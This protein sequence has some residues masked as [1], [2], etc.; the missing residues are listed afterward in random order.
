MFEILFRNFWLI[1]IGVSVL[2]YFLIRKKIKPFIEEDPSREPGY[3]QY[4]N[5]FLLL[6]ILPWLIV[7][8]ASLSGKV[9]TI[10]DFLHPGAGNWMVQT[11]WGFSGTF[12]L[13]FSAWIILGS[14]AEFFEQHPGLLRVQVPGI[15]PE[16]PTA[17][18]I[19]IVWIIA[20]ILIVLVFGLVFSKENGPFGHMELPISPSR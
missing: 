8:A 3:E 4:L 17:R 13:I 12:L 16:R 5:Y 15:D 11:F 19:R 9:D 20:F 14:G 6:S 10:F 1:A 2:N 7:G 18:Q